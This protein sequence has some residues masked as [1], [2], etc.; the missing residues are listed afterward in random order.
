[1]S[2]GRRNALQLRAEAKARR[3]IEQGLHALRWPL[4]EL[5]R[6]RKGDAEGVRNACRL[7]Q[8]TRMPLAWIAQ[9]LRVGAAGHVSRLLYRK[10]GDK[11]DCGDINPEQTMMDKLF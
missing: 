3:I 10:E 8:E 11:P 6:R 7:R 9:S 1:M 2:M 4:E 5:K